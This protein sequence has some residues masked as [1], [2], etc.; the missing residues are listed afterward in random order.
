[1]LSP[2]PGKKLLN[3]GLKASSRYKKKKWNKPVL[4]VS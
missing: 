3:S 4:D 2:E 1:M